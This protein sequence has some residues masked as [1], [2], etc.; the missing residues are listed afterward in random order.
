MLLIAVL[1]IPVTCVCAA[2]V[3]TREKLF[4]VFTTKKEVKE[5]GMQKGAS[6]DFR[7]KPFFLSGS[8]IFCVILMNVFFGLFSVS[9]LVFDHIL[10]NL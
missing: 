9:L 8:N 3:T 7:V 10:I 1:T 5:P 6:T 2:G 4:E